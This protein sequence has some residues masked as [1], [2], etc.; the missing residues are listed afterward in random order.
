M[1]ATTS[2]GRPLRLTPAMR[3][4]LETVDAG[5]ASYRY[6]YVHGMVPST[7][8][9]LKRRGLVKVVGDDYRNQQI[10]RA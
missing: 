6:S 9:A 8:A 5:Q 4:A 3:E 7:F 10:V 1:T 2:T